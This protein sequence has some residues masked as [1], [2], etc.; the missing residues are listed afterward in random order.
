MEPDFNKMEL[1]PAIVQDD[2]TKEVL[3]L[4]YVNKES[5]Q[6]MQEKKETCFYSRSRQKLW[7]KG[8]TSGHFQKIKQMKLD[9][10]QDALLIF[11]DPIGGACHTGEFSCFH[12]VVLERKE[13]KQKTDHMLEEIYQRIVDRDQNPKEGSYTNYLLD[14]GVDKICKKVGEEATETVIAAKNHDPEELKKEICDLIY[15]VEVLM[16]QQGVTLEQI[17]KEL[18][19]RYQI[20]GNK[21]IEKTRGEY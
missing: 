11:V 9:C 13:K 18:E 12:H 4:A 19:K 17:K 16:Y 7:H 15:H 6:F 8:E 1:I 20:E 14:Q 3:M 10:D 2:S 5:Y 21:K